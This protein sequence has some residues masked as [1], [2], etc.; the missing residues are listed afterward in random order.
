MP[1]S[2]V[3]TSARTMELVQK[4][5][6]GHQDPDELT[7]LGEI[8]GLFDGRSEQERVAAAA[9]GFAR[10]DAGIPDDQ[11]GT[12]DLIA[13]THTLGLRDGNVQG[14]LADYRTVLGSFKESFP[15]GDE[16]RLGWLSLHLLSAPLTTESGDP[17]FT[18]A[19]LAAIVRALPG[20]ESNATPHQVERW[21]W[22]VASELSLNQALSAT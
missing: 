12:S 3:D 20:E 10:L 9:E 6:P 15:A 11:A 8:S 5:F 17:M 19:Q 16:A 18:G 21:A 4:I 7:A 14:L 22:N 13:L 2:I 1:S